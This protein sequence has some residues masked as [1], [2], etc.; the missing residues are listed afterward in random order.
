M[1]AAESAKKDRP[2]IVEA[3][4]IHLVDRNRS[5]DTLHPLHGRCKMSAKKS[6]TE[7]AG[8]PDCLT[9]PP[10]GFACYNCVTRTTIAFY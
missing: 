3:S 4:P 8:A 1:A 2:L 6:D 5:E 9:I 7:K 10:V